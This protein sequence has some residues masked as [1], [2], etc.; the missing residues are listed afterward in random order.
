[1]HPDRKRGPV[2][3]ARP[4]QGA[5]S[6]PQGAGSP[7]RGAGARR[8]KPSPR[9]RFS[10]AAMP[11]VPAAPVAPAAPALAPYARFHLLDGTHPWRDAAPD[12]YIDYPV[13]LRPGGRV[14]Y[15]NDPLARE[16]GLIPSAH[17]DRM[18]ATLEA[19]I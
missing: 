1:M 4:P 5:G 14:I 19:I 3:L 13:R 11:L 18:N 17:L 15:F 16:L 7:P 9:R 12:G 8:G 2:P 10:A 6:P